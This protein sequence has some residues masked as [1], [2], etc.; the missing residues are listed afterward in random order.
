MGPGVQVGRAG[1]QC[2]GAAAILTFRIGQP[3]QRRRFLRPA[4]GNYIELDRAYVQPVAGGQ[5]GV[6][7]RGAVE[8]GVR[9][10]AAD[11]R[12][13]PASH[14][15]AVDRMDARRSKPHR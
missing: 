2:L 12:A 4:G 5:F 6:G 1:V 3:R 15:Q 7:K 14:D 8:Q 9:T 13:L 10:P 11:D